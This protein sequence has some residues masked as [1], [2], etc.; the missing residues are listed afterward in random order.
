[1]KAR[2]LRDFQVVRSQLSGFH[3]GCIIT[4]W[5]SASVSCTRVGR[6]VQA[7][8][9]YY[10]ESAGFYECQWEDRRTHGPSQ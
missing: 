8:G 2:V 5:S 1:M 10:E 6:M 3:S 9:L 4:R 7:V